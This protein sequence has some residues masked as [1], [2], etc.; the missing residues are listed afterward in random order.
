[1]RDAWAELKL[2]W[3]RSAKL[4]KDYRTQDEKRILGE[5]F[6]RYQEL[7]KL[8]WQDIVYCPKNGTTFLCIDAGSTGV[9]KCQ[10]LG[11]WP[12]GAWWILEAGDMWPSRPILW[13]PLPPETQEVKP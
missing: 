7:V 10:Y 13:K 5:M 11:E 6:S 2:H 9:H 3:E 4:D 1:M 8:G 12:K